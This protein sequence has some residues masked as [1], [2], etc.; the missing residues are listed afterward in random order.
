M[1][2]LDIKELVC[3][4]GVEK[5]S[6]TAVQRALHTQKKNSVAL[7]RERTIP[8]ERLLPVGEVNANFCG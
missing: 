5:E 7:F 4:A 3:S 6:V 8:T 1:A 2:T